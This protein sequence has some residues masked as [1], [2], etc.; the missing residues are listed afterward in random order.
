MSL[1]AWMFE[2]YLCLLQYLGRAPKDLERITSKMKTL[3]DLDSMDSGQYLASKREVRR[4][5]DK[6]QWTLR[7]KLEG[8]LPE[9]AK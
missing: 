5:T 1:R 6:H 7:S 8:V 9:T 3:E 2:G 4:K